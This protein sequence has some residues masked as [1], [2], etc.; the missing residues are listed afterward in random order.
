[1]RRIDK[2]TNAPVELIFVQDAIAQD[3]FE[4]KENFSW[5]TEHYSYPIKDKIKLIYNNKCAFCETKLTETDTEN[6]FT[7]EHF[8]PKGHYYWLGAEWSN[9]FP[10]CLKCNNNKEDEFPLLIERKRIHKENAPF[11]NSGKLIKEL[12]DAK[13]VNFLNEKAL[14]LHPEIDFPE[15][16][17]KF[18]PSGKAIVNEKN[19]RTPY[20]KAQAQKMIDKFLKRPS[21]EE[22]RKDK[23]IK[24]RKRLT[25]LLIKATPILKQNY[26][27]RDITLLFLGFF[28]DLLAQQEKEAE[29]SLLGYYMVVDFHKFFTEDIEAKFGKELRNLVEFAYNLFIDNRQ[30][31]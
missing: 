7:V 24:F 3:L 11:N 16:Y 26:T 2:N 27:K 22:K 4:K 29:F 5:R 18:E 14:F 28:T 6:K 17:F 25:N 19:L 21:V 15:K 31:N 10:T 23:I 20:E 1:M 9:L 12:C 13:H 30:S 8:R